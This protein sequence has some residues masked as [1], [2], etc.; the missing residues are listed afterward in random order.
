M[1]ACVTSQ[2]RQAVDCGRSGEVQGQVHSR[3]GD[4]NGVLIKVVVYEIRATGVVRIAVV[5][6]SRIVVVRVRHHAVGVGTN[7]VSGASIG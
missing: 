2:V 3:S 1:I 6:A 7:Q 5:A 4:N